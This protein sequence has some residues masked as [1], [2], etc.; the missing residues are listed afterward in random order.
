MVLGVNRKR[1]RSPSSEEE[2]AEQGW[3]GGGGGG[4][5]NRCGCK[6]I[7]HWKTDSKGM[8]P[9]PPATDPASCPKRD[10]PGNTVPLLLP[11]ANSFQRSAL[12]PA[13]PVMTSRTSSSGSPWWPVR[14]LQPT[15][16]VQDRTLQQETKRDD[17]RR[18]QSA[19]ADQPARCPTTRTTTTR[20]S[21]SFNSPIQR[22]LFSC[23]C[24]SFTVRRFGRATASAAD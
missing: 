3:A 14:S 6:R 8:W 20:M 17:R 5:D 13:P 22:F 1:L 21:I 10:G 15:V 7:T 11:P 23:L 12:H 2:E 24:V 19:E 18:E 4:A 9:R 16:K